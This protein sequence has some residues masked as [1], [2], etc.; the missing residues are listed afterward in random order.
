MTTSIIFNQA[1]VE[2]VRNMVFRLGVTKFGGKPSS[3]E[4]T[5]IKSITDLPTLEQLA[6]RVLCV[7]TWGEL[8]QD[9]AKP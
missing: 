2:A 1:R 9:I 4:E 7:I 5:A 8:L 6:G 3:E